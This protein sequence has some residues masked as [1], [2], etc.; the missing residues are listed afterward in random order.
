MAEGNWSVIRVE[1]ISAEGAQ[2]TERHNERKNESYANLNV[3]SERIARNVHFKDTGGLTYNEYFQ[4]LI[5]ELELSAEDAFSAS[6]PRMGRT[7]ATQIS[8]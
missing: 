4:R 5:D 1:K 3:D 8:M 7:K 2:K 6:A